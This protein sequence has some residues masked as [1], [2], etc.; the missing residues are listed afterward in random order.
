MKLA[1]SEVKR[2]NPT[3]DITDGDI[4]MSVDLEAR[5]DLVDLGI[6]MRLFEIGAGNGKFELKSKGRFDVVGD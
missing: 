4:T 1:P 5:I 2:Q 3:L 6:A